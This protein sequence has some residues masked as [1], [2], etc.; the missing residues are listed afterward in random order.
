M[1]P[2][3]HSLCYSSLAKASIKHNSSARGMTRVW[4]GGKGPPPLQHQG[5][6]SARR[7]LTQPLPLLLSNSHDRTQSRHQGKDKRVGGGG[8]GPP[9]PQCRDH[10]SACGPSTQPVPLFLSDSR[11]QTQSWH[12]GN[13]EHAWG[14]RGCPRCNAKTICWCADHQHSLCHF[15]S[16]T[17]ATNH[18]R[19]AGE[20]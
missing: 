17:A 1:P 12:Q 6:L 13:N 5:H 7:L 2:H 8:E 11:N 15:S 10:L 14:P 9:V 16:A 3:Q 18:N 19:G 20:Q 4:G